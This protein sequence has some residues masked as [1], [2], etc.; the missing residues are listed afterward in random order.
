[1]G[2]VAKQMGTVGAQLD[3]FR[4]QRVG[5]VGIAIV[6][7]I[8]ERLPDL[9]AKR[10]ITRKAQHRIDRRT[11]VAHRERPGREIL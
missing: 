11:R 1:M 10:S 4:D 3:D 5:V 9:L 2:L 8:D 7:A 6:A